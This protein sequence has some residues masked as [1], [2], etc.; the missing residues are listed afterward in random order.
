MN[1]GILGSGEVAKTLADGFLQHGH[2]V[3]LGTRAPAKLAE[4]ATAHPTA[5]IASFADAAGFG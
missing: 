4:W 2:E 3:M 1:V 5:S